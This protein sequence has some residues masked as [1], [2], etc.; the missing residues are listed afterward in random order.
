MRE[1]PSWLRIFELPMPATLG[2]V[3]TYLVKGPRG[4]GLIDTGMDDVNSVREL[5][6]LLKEEGM[7]PGSIEQVICTHHHP[8]HCGIGKTL[9]GFGARVLM[10]EPDAGSLA[11]FLSNPEIDRQRATFFGRHDVPDEFCDR[12]T[13]MFPFFRKLQESFVPDGFLGDGQIVDIG[14]VELEVMLTPGHT[15]GHICLIQRDA[16]L[17]FTGDHIIS[18]DATHVSMR[19]EVHGTDPLGKFVRS[20]EGVRDLG[21]MVGLGGHGEPMP[22]IPRRADQLVRHH[23][24][25]IDRVAKTLSD[26]PRKAFDLSEEAL[27]SRKK[28]FARWLSMSQTLS[29]LEHLVAR[30]EAVEVTMDKGVGYR[31]I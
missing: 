8:D 16:G 11:L 29:Y 12:M 25:R 7:E 30:D 14:G 28:V 20:L 23:R 21:P 3:N 5:F 15:R 22:D 4:L 2:A 18:G 6:G 26:E 31:R 27:G 10:S 1:L 24:A 19:E 17:I 13:P 9:Q